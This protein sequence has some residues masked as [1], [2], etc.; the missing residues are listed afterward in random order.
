[1]W[2][3]RAVA[4]AMLFAGVSLLVASVSS[5]VILSQLPA[6]RTIAG[7]VVLI[8]VALAV[9]GAAARY[10]SHPRGLLLANERAAIGN[11]EPPALD[12]WLIALAITL[13]ALP[14]WLVVS[15]RSFLA[16]WVLVA[17]LLAAPGLWESADF[18]MAGVVLVPL[19]AA[20]TPPALELTAAV[21][22]VIASVVSLTLLLSRSR[23]FPRA[24][25]VCVVLLSA[26]V[27]ASVLGA[28]AA[29]V[30]AGAVRPLIEGSSRPDE[31][32]Q[33]VEGLARYTGVVSSTAPVLVWTLCGYLVWVPALI[34]SR[35]VAATFEAGSSG[36]ASPDAPATDI[37]SITSPPR[38]PR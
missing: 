15:L 38:F 37:E 19:A 36:D 12:G 6:A 28:R 17:R 25:L 1:M 9:S 13:L 26:L 14:V 32:T 31:R 24:Y 30:A 23:R 29:M 35:R 5:L 8:G 7:I 21:A 34:W 22:F 11:A 18:N 20:L 27:L 33:I 16:E 2:T 4:T 10:L 3:L